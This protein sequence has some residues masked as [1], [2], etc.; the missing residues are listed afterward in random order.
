MRWPQLLY[1]SAPLIAY[2]VA[3]KASV[4]WDSLAWL[5]LGLLFAA[6]YFPC[7]PGFFANCSHCREF[8][9][10]QFPVLPGVVPSLLMIRL[11]GLGRLPDWIELSLATVIMCG[12]LSLL[13]ITMRRGTLWLAG[14]LAFALI[15]SSVATWVLYCLVRA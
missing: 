9:I 5:R 7:L 8:W 15:G 10:W 2:V 4:M 11:V 13:V 14:S 3:R 1:F 6:V 12:L